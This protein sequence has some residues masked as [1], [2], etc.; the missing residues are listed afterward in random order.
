MAQPVTASVMIDIGSLE[1]IPLPRGTPKVWFRRGIRSGR[2]AV[3]E[4][5]D[6]AGRFVGSVPG[7]P[8]QTDRG[9]T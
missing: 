6:G 8:G 4:H 1:L 3:A 2:G 9:W 7:D 5:R